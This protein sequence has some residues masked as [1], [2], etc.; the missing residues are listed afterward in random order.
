MAPKVKSGESV[1]VLAHEVVARDA[2]HFCSRVGPTTYTA[3]G[4]TRPNAVVWAARVSPTT[5]FAR[6]GINLKTKRVSGNITGSNG[7]G[8]SRRFQQKSFCHVC[9]Q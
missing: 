1:T 6:Y 9:W 7:R 4:R 8:H 5:A 3:L 2:R